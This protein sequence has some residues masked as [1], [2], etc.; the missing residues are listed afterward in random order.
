LSPNR[1][2][3]S[4]LPTDILLCIPPLS[5]IRAACPALFTLRQIL[6]PTA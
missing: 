5:S 3:P 6:E 4:G 1:L 2:S